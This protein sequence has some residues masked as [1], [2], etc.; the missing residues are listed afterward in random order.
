[1]VRRLQTHKPE[2][3]RILSL[4]PD[5]ASPPLKADAYSFV[6]PVDFPISHIGRFN[7]LLAIGLAEGIDRA[8][9]CR[10]AHQAVL[11]EIHCD[12]YHARGDFA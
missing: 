9:C 6:L 8:E 4:V 12:D 11:N 10:L 2:M 7:R 3:L 1:M 5:Q